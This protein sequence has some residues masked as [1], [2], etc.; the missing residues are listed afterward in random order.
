MNDLG[1]YPRDLHIMFDNNKEIN[2][3]YFR[4]MF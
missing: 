3:N 1:L 2:V 4:K